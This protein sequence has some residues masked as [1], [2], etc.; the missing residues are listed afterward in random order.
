[1]ELGERNNTYNINNDSYLLKNG[2]MKPFN[3][4]FM[5]FLLFKMT[6]IFSC[7][8]QNRTYIAVYIRTQLTWLSLHLVQRKVYAREERWQVWI[9]VFFP[10]EMLFFHNNSFWCGTNWKNII[11]NSF[12]KSE[13]DDVQA[14]QSPSTGERSNVFVSFN[15]SAKCGHNSNGLQ[16]HWIC[17]RWEICCTMWSAVLL[18]NGARWIQSITLKLCGT[19]TSVDYISQLWYNCAPSIHIHSK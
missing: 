4:I 14:I 8:T 13:D 7:W 3:K 17:D 19:I 2:N 18:Q 5:G 16:P 10:D 6:L 15:W 12:N 11:Y 9:I 1:M